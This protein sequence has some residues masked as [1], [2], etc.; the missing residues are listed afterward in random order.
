MSKLDVT[1]LHQDYVLTCPDGQ[2]AQLLEAVERVDQQFQKMRDSSKLR[3][4]E[5]VAV[6]LAVNLAFENLK[7]REQLLDL[8]QLS[9]QLSNEDGER[10]QTLEAL[11]AQEQAQAE[12]LLQRL[13]QALGTEPSSAD[14]A[15]AQPSLDNDNG[16]ELPAAP[17]E[18]Q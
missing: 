12:Q 2:E 13:D 5:H 3:A 14:E 7:L 16:V 9:S 1:I 11:L 4:R 8:Q 10:L 6:L 17:Q 18:P 15:Q